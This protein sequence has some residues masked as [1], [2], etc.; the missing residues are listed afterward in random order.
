MGDAAPRVHVGLLVFSF[1][2]L[3]AELI[4][5]LLSEAGKYILKFHKRQVR[6]RYIGCAGEFEI[7]VLFKRAATIHE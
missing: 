5:A 6:K 3:K 2:V 4:E 7:S 1:E